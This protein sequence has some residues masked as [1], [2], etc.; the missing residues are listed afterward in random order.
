MV[1]SIEAYKLFY[2][3]YIAVSIALLTLLHEIGHKIFAK[4]FD[5]RTGP[6]IFLPF[7][8]AF[9]ALLDKPKSRYESAM[10]S[11]GGPCAGLLGSVILYVATFFIDSEV[12]LQSVYRV[13]YLNSLINLFN[14][15]PFWRLDGE[16]FVRPLNG[17]HIL[18]FSLALGG[19]VGYA[20]Y[21]WHSHEFLLL[22]FVGAL[23][24]KTIQY[25]VKL[26]SSNKPKGLLERLREK[27]IDPYMLVPLKQGEMVIC[28]LGYLI[29]SLA[30]MLLVIFTSTHFVRHL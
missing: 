21:Q 19:V 27:P 30:L 23:L 5:V 17:W 22:F 29:T 2:D 6:P 3:Y 24:V 15:V 1:I 14:L 13:I 12:L 10:I 20:Y 26:K 25:F 18:I 4:K 9:V 16:S 8:G 7:F 11:F 28:F